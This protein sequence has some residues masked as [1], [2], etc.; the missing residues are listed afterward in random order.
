MAKDDKNGVSS[1]S[2]Y[3]NLRVACDWNWRHDDCVCTIYFIIPSTDVSIMYHPVFLQLYTLVIVLYIRELGLHEIT[4]F[5]RYMHEILVQGFFRCVKVGSGTI[6][7][8]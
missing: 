5:I 4:T 8:Q 7:T 6:I 2:V 1:A 3:S